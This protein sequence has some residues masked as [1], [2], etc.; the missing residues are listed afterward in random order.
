MRLW[1][2][3]YLH[4]KEKKRGEYFV[5]IFCCKNTDYTRE[6]IGHRRMFNKMIYNSEYY[7]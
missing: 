2:V 4:I 1:Y 5:T 3:Y 6:Y 7:L